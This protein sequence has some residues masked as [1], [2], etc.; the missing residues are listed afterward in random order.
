MCEFCKNRNS[1]KFRIND[2]NKASESPPSHTVDKYMKKIVNKG[3]CEH[4]LL[5]LRRCSEIG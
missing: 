5:T 3:N 2:L 1:Y 4:F